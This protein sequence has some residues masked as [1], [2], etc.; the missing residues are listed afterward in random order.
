MINKLASLI[1]SIYI[2]SL[3][4]TNAFFVKALTIVEAPGELF[5]NHLT[6]LVILVGLIYFVVKKVISVPFRRGIVGNVRAVILSVMLV[7]LIVSILY[8]VLSVDSVY[9]LP[10]QLDRLFASD[11]AFTV[12]LILP[13]IALFI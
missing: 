8:N 9:N 5:F 10:S 13:L 2:A 7:G 6:I 3:I 1:V 4:Y 12:W 11:T